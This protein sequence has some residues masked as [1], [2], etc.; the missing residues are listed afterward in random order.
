[1]T[2]RSATQCLATQ[3]TLRGA[4]VVLLAILSGCAPNTL[5]VRSD[6]PDARVLL[7]GR[8]T[9]PGKPVDLP[10]FGT[11]VGDLDPREGPRDAWVRG[12][13]RASL[14]VAPPA[15]GWLFPLDLGIEAIHRLLH[16]P[17]HDE[18][19]VRSSLVAG[20]VVGTPPP[21][22]PELRARADAAR[23]ER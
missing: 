5:A 2:N 19:V 10:Y 11:Y 6:A 18:M 4:S 1:M 7:D 3:G 13:A 22:L 12:S 20:T 23:T 9:K 17:G 21:R 15:P 8:E 16:G 14:S